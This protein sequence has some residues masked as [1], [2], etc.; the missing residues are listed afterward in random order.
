MKTITSRALIGA[1][2]IAAAAALALG[3]GIVA[4]AA[5][6]TPS[7]SSASTAAPATT[8]TGVPFRAISANAIRVEFGAVP[9]ALQADLKALHGKKGADRK[10]AVS[11]I[12]T[13]ALNGA[14]GSDVKS[15]AT[16]AKT[17]WKSVPSSLKSA[18]KTAQ[19]APKSDRSKDYADIDSSALDGH[20]GSA[21]ESWAKT[22]QGNVQKEQ[23]ATLASKAGAVI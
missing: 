9:A 11:A 22:V 4:S 21:I 20:Y 18:L 23:A 12:E 2:G 14:Y 8:P 10:A 15:A 19:H 6:P 3:G 1:A 13:K 17:A 7:S 16:D 5:T